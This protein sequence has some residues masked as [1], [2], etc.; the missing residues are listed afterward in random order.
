VSGRCSSNLAELTAD[1]SEEEE[2]FILDA[3]KLTS[4]IVSSSGPMYD[5]AHLLNVWAVFV[6]SLHVSFRFRFSLQ[7]IRITADDS[8]G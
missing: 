7:R 8:L 5:V 1:T 2:K 6:P 4:D 3:K